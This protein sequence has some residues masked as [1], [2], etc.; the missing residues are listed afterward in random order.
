VRIEVKN[1]GMM[2]LGMFVT[3][4]FQAQA[5]VIYTAVPAS[6]VM[7]LHDR[8]WVY[9]PTADQQ[10]R[11]VEVVAGN[12]LPGEMQEVKSGLNPGQTIVRDALVLD[13]ALEL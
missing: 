9:L 2:R 7:R 6:A 8:D 1:P 12:T 3:A 10:F 4:T 13:R 5:P 11:R